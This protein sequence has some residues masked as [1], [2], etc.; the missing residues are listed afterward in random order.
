MPLEIIPKKT[1]TG[2]PFVNLLLCFSLV[3]FVGAIL[4]LFVLDFYQ[5]KSEKNFRQIEN[6]IAEKETPANKALEQEVLKYKEK[7]DKIA[8]LLVSHQ[9]SSAFFPLLGKFSHPKVAFSSL[10]LNLKEN[11]ATL[12]GTTESF[13]TLGQ[14]IHVL[15]REKSIT[16][17]NVS[18][19]SIGAKGDIKFSLDLSLDPQ[20]FK[21]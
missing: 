3:L 8:S 5:S 20:I 17:A 4:S 19:I 16:N 11:K 15:K 21:Y 18:G 13:Q 14:Q 6:L 12:A 2:F 7:I 9:K 1:D 10:S